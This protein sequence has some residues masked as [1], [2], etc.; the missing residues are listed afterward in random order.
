MSNHPHLTGYCQDKKLLSD[1]MR[2]VNSL[3]ARIYNKKSQR[4]GQVV[5]DR[6]K[7][8]TIHTEFN[9]LQVMYYID[10]NPKRAHIVCHP[11]EYKWSSYRYYAFGKAD[12]LLTPAPCYLN[13]GDTPAL[14]QK[15]YRMMVEAIL[16]DDW[17]EKKPYSSA[18]FIGD[19]Q[20]VI[21]RMEQLKLF[22][23]LQR[24]SFQTRF[25][26]KFSKI[27]SGFS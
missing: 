6:F 22:T 21:G 19:P 11:Q 10:L 5:M 14:R 3:F 13:L 23:R 8:P 2:T 24:K 25:L 17:K 4:R 7:S 27:A 20:W 26:E 9:H 16:K 15:N 18:P 12:P 1:F